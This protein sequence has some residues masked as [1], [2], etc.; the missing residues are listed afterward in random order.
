M[1]GTGSI[2]VGA[3][4]TF[5]LNEN[6]TLTGGAQLTKV[7]GGTLNIA[8]GKTLRL[9]SGSDYVLAADH[10][11]ATGNIVVTG[12]GS[13]LQSGTTTVTSGAALTVQ[14][15][16]SVQAGTFL[17]L[18]GFTPQLGDTFDLLDV[19]TFAGDFDSIS[20]PALSGGNAWDFSALKTTGSVS[21]VPE[22]GIGALLASE[23]AL[24]GL[25]RRQG[26]VAARMQ[27]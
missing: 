11:L 13:T 24:F 22:P 26:L 4:A 8:S 19:G 14:N 15:G 3:A 2:A 6:L 20:A 23:V 17:L 16:G 9:E 25:R 27:N 1:G 12:A 18:G 5:N 10:T 7:C 21:V